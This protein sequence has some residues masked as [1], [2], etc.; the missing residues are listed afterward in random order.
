MKLLTLLTFLITNI[1]LGHCAFVGFPN[2]L[3][4]PGQSIGP[5]LVWNT[6]LPSLRYQQ[7]YG[8]SGF[9]GLGTSQ[10][11]ITDLFFSASGPSPNGSVVLPNIRIDFSTTSKAPDGLSTVLA[12]NVGANDTV[13]YSGALKFFLDGLGGYHIPLQTPFLF[14]P[15]AGNLLMDVRN[16]QPVSPPPGG[17]RAYTAT[18]GT[19]GDTISAAFAENANALTGGVDTGGLETVFGGAL[20][21]EPSTWALLLTGGVLF[22]WTAR[23]RG[24]RARAFVKRA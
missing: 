23:R 5:F 16:F 6:D 3:D 11:M 2:R 19:F 10:F 22:A 21:P 4:N 13:V 17:V 9:T 8:A 20:V 15:S 18:E 12:E 14:D 7:V 24:R 1:Q